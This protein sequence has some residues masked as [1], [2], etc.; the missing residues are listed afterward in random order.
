MPTA[1]NQGVVEGEVPRRRSIILARSRVRISVHGAVSCKCAARHDVFVR[2]RSRE[3]QARTYLSV[4]QNRSSGFGC[5]T[6]G[7]W[8]SGETVGYCM[9]S[10]C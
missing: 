8:R 10:W 1:P 9:R 2:G 6:Q 7:L 3:D 5:C 4:G